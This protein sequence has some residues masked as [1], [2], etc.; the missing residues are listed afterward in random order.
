MTP[1]GPIPACGA[2]HEYRQLH[3]DGSCVVILHC[4]R[5]EGH[6][7]SHLAYGSNSII[8]WKQIRR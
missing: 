1:S 5:L 8:Q 2:R 3:A 7:G 4:L 6:L